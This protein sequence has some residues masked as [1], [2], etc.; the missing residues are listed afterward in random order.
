M[1]TREKRSTKSMVCVTMAASID[2]DVVLMQLFRHSPCNGHLLWLYLLQRPQVLHVQISRIDHC[3]ARH[4]LGAGL[5]RARKFIPPGPSPR[6]WW[7]LGRFR[8]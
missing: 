7:Q 2:T 3:F 4:I 1:R 6:T 8:L 5:L